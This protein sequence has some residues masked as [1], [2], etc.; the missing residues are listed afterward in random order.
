VAEAVR[1]LGVAER[2]LILA[3][4]GARWAAQ[5]IAAL[6]GRLG[7]P[8]VMTTNGRGILAGRHPLAVPA[9]P[10]LEAIR[11]LVARSDV[12][13]ALGTE[14]GWTDY[15][16][17]DHGEFGIPG[18]LIRIDID[19]E[20]MRRG[21]VPD[22]ALPGDVGAGVTAL[23]A[24]LGEGAP[25]DGGA[26]R[27]EAALGAAFE[28]IGPAYRASAGFLETVRDTLPEAPVFGDS[29]HAIY[30][31]NLYYAATGPNRWFNAATG[32][33]AL[34]YGLPAAI[35]AA[36]ATGGTVVCI[37][38]DGG[39]QFTLT[40]LGTA[41]EEGLR[42]IVLVSNNQGYGEIRNY[43]VK[44][45]ITPVG[46]DLH[47]PDFVAIARAYGMAGV[48]MDTLGALPALLGEA[49]ARPG[50]TLIEFDQALVT[51]G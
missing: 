7:A 29:T 39:L 21:A 24:A 3:G 34:G 40:E 16:M 47:T 26:A 48:R 10:S 25:A 8:V 13:L 38:G 22:L 35:G 45:G 32:Y 11:E 2:P 50:P 23:L 30:G 1:L 4:G 51:G 37:A 6:A 42:V 20:Q 31:G 27:A 43:M 18:R 49:A 14:I 41:V 36:R 46:V 33:G 5:G 12:V 17:F 44:A 9:S 15:N 19:P 28:E